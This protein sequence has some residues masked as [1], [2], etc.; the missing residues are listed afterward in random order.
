[1]ACP[2][3]FLNFQTCFIGDLILRPFDKKKYPPGGK[4]GK[5]I[6]DATDC[7]PPSPIVFCEIGTPNWHHLSW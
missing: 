1:M 5:G 7:I 3:R 4:R 2:R 6:A